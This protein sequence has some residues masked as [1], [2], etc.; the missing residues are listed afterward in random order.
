M[1]SLPV[2]DPRS[3]TGGSCHG[4]ATRPAA[5]HLAVGYREQEEAVRQEEKVPGTGGDLQETQWRG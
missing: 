5:L 3:Y 1:T 2:P 4:G